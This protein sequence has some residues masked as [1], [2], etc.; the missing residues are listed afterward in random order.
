M[1][2]NPQLGDLG[3]VHLDTVDADKVLDEPPRTCVE[4]MG[5]RGGHCLKTLESIECNVVPKGEVE[6]AIFA[7]LISIFIFRGDCPTK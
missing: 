6:L 5:E 2:L 1:G 4:R 3:I 7:K